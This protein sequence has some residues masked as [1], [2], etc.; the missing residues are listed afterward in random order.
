MDLDLFRVALRAI[1]APVVAEIPDQF[2]FLGVDRDHRLLFSQS[3]G[4]LALDIA[5]LRIP[6]GVAVALRGLAVAL[7]TVTCLIEQ[8]ADQG[9]ADFVTLRLQ[10]LR[11]TAHA[12]A[13]P[14]QR[15]FRIPAGRRLDQGFEIGEQ[16]RVLGNRRLAPRSRPPNPFRR[17]I[18][19]QFLQ[20]P[21]DR[22][23]RNP[24]RHRDPCDP[25]ITR[26]D[27]LRRRDQTTASF[28][29]KRG[30]RRKPLSDRFDIDH[31]HNIWYSNLVVNPYITLSKVDSIIYGRALISPTVPYSISRSVA[32]ARASRDLSVP[33]GMSRAPAGSA[34]VNPSL[35]RQVHECA[36]NLG[37]TQL[38][39]LNGS[40][41]RLLRWR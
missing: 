29:E 4:Y 9:A 22:A 3:G 26:G 34:K 27:C 13:G 17:L 5:D 32:R 24:R 37:E 2:F 15:R 11:Q 8:V 14:P 36:P 23:R 35:F 12:L 33:V 38:M 6:V 7:Q 16:R 30:H 31:H 19:R 25:T 10:R 28:I 18:L 39:V 21:P 41:K 20:A 1:F 40:E